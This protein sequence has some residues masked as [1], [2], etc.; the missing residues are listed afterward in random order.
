MKHWKAKHINREAAVAGKF[1]KGSKSELERE[2]NELFA[3]ATEK[4]NEKLPLQALI[5]PHAGYIFSGKVAASAFNQVDENTKYERVFVLAS[6]HRYHFNG[7]AVY[8]AGNY[9]TPLGEITVDIKLCKQLAKSSDVFKDKPEAHLYEHSLEV[10]LPFLQYKLGNTVKLV[11]II[12]GTNNPEDCKELAKVLAPYFTSENLFV[13]STDFSHYPAYDDANKLDFITA[14]TICRNEPDEL[15]ATLKNNA[16]LQVDKLSTSLCGWTSVLTLLYLT[17]GKSYRYLQIDYQNS[18]DEKRYGDKEG[19]VGYW[20]IA[21]F[22]EDLRFQISKTEEAELLE[23]ARQSITH[24]LESGKKGKTPSPDPKGILASRTGAFVSVYIKGKLRGC[25]GAF[26]SDKSLNKVIR[27]MAV[28]AVGD[29]RFKAVKKEELKDMTLEVSVLSPLKKIH[30]SDE[31]ELGRHGIYIK[32]GLNTGTYLPQVA[33]KTG[34]NV[35]EFL[36]HCSQDKAGLGWE[37]W[38]QAELFTYEAVIIK[39]T[40]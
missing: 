16:K 31:I 27:T 22:N 9:K 38:R 28:S 34:W 18:G 13:F 4:S 17:Q 30:S 3:R 8:T 40:N 21:V 29:R 23:L 25:I 5:S 10:Q 6:S 36:G 26:A 11:P 12:L 37:G 24:Y 33:E 39:E 7:A 14:N 32:K 35:L 20:A 15:L 2:L 19:V 1:Y